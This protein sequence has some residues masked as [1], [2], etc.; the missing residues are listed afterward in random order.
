MFIVA[1]NPVSEKLQFERKSGGGGR[2]LME[3]SVNKT[4]IFWRGGEGIIKL[5]YSNP[6]KT[7]IMGHVE[8]KTFDVTRPCSRAGR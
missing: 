8:N 6:C 5:Q 7:I 1:Q 3:G 2:S 4:N